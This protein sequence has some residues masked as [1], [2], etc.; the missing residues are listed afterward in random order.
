[1]HRPDFYL[2]L[3]GK[4]DVLT[5]LERFDDAVAAATAAMAARPTETGPVTDRAFAYLKSKRL[6]EALADYDAAHALG[7][8]TAETN[9]LHAIALSQRAV[10]LDKAGDAAGA[11]SLY[12]RAIA[13]EATEARI[14][15]RAFLFMRTGRTPDAIEGF[16]HVLRVN[17][18]H[19]QV[20]AF[21]ALLGCE[22][23]RCESLLVTPS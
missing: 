12:D 16:R 22:F 15:N 8:N 17:P 9:R 20:R 13:I 2:S 23:G 7:D 19:Y 10:E 6:D 18:E 3:R 14:F 5:Q 1:M 11:E 4:A 21:P